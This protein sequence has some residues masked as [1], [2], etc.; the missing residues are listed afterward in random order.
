MKHRVRAALALAGVALLAL[1]PIGSSAVGTDTSKLRDAVTVK[2]VMAHEKALQKIANQNDGT[3]ASGTSGYDASV[4]YVAGKLRGAG[5]DVTV[6]NFT[7]DKFVLSS[8][9]FERVS[10]TRGR[11]SR[12]STRLTTTSRWTTRARAT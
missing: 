11:T 8:S 5:Y 9:A 7:Y 3:R 10:P 1:V 12:A 6:Q 2:G 4:E